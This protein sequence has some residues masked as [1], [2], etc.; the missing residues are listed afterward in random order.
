[1]IKNDSVVIRWIP[2]IKSYYENLGYIWTKQGNSFSVKIEELLPTSSAIIDLECDEC[3][4]LFKRK[5]KDRVRQYQKHNKDLCNSC[6]KSGDRN[7]QFD[8]DRSEILAHARSFQTKNPMKGRRHKLESKAKMS[9]AKSSLIANGEFNIKSNNRG[10][11]MTHVS[12]KSNETFYADSALEKLRMIQLDNDKSVKTWT[13][14]HGIKIPYS[15]NNQI[16]NY[17]PDFYI[18]L[19]DGEIIIEETKGNVT[20]VDLIKKDYAEIY[21]SHRNWTYKF[22]TQQ[23]MNKNGEYRAFLKSIRKEK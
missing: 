8:K 11:K 16:K 4:K 20:N 17:V 23:D 21:C 2:K 6:A 1:M 13:K 5:W 10:I 15:F 22:V 14:R 3:K 12:T 9:L 19:N 18:E 7:S